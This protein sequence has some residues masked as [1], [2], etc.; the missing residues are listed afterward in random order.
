MSDYF[1]SADFQRHREKINKIL[2]GLSFQESPR[3]WQ[4][5]FDAAIGGMTYIGFSESHDCLLTV[6]S[7]G[8]GLWDLSTGKKIARDYEKDGAWLDE[9][10]LTCMG[11]GL[12]EDETVRVAGLCG[13]GLLTST[14]KGESLELVSPLYPCHDVV[15]QSNYQ[16]CFSEGKNHD[17]VIIFRGF[18]K[19]YGFS[20]PG[21]YFVIA[22]EDIH[23]WGRV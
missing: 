11:I 19:M 6:S 13:G 5:K 10:K 23:V 18:V 22:D 1:K 12:I 16:S 2:S 15:F 8:R 20:Y 17:C 4:K 14:D 7:S 9:R 21:D 3:G